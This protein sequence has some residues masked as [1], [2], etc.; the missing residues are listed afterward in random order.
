MVTMARHIGLDPNNPQWHRSSTSLSRHLLSALLLTT[1]ITT[2]VHAYTPLSTCTLQHLTFGPSSD[3]DIHNGFGSSSLLAPILIPRVPG[4]E[5]SRLV[6]QHFV[7]FFS[8]QLPDWTLEWQNSTSTTPAT[9]S[10]LIPFANLILRRDPPWAK[11]GNVK[12]LTLAAHYDSLFRPEGFIGAVDSAAPCAILMAVARAV[13][14]A[15]G[16]RWEGVMAAKEKRE[17][18]GERDAGDGLEDEEGGEEEEEKGVQIVLFDGE[19]AWERWTNT[20]STYGSRALAEAWQSSPYEASSTHSNRLESISLLV[21]L[22]L[23]GAGNP[24]IPSY[25]W[26]TH[27]A[28]K[29]L[30]KIETRLRKLGVLETAPASPFLPDSEKPYNRFTRG[31]I[32]DD[33]V[34]FMERGVKV[35]HIIPTPFPPVWHTMDDDGEHLD[36]PTVRDWAK[37]MTVFVAEWMDLDGVLSQESCAAQKEKGSGS[38]EKDEL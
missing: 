1:T 36:L 8:S 38:M 10:Q 20:D 23:L 35:L 17:G 16:R 12:R 22:D 27:G 31:Y 13:D 7:D 25:F 3:F 37:I 4:T 14:G 2:G 30:A 28:Y 18:G 21:L 32:Q 9:G 24:R 11:A 29:D 19:E 26:D 6:Q 34:P 5:G 33:H 15:L